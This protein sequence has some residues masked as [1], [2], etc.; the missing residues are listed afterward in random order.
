MEFKITHKSWD[1]K[2][3]TIFSSFLWICVHIFFEIHFLKNDLNIFL[4]NWIFFVRVCVCFFCGWKM[5]GIWVR[6]VMFWGKKISDLA[7]RW[8][9]RKI[10]EEF[11][12]LNHSFTT[13]YLYHHHS[14]NSVKPNERNL[15]KKTGLV[16]LHVLQSNFS[17]VL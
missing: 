8:N 17:S 11:W 13:R 5:G 10:W 4:W 1:E 7:M 12:F 14:N 9:F 3:S 2:L 15:L 6:F 16:I